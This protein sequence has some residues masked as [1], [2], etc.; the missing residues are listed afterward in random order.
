MLLF[1]QQETANFK[2]REQVSEKFRVLFG[3]GLFRYLSVARCLAVPLLRARISESLRPFWFIV[4]V[5]S[6]K[7]IYANLEN[8]SYEKSFWNNPDCGGNRLPASS[9]RA[10]FCR[11]NRRIFGR[12]SCN[13]SS[14]LFFVEEQERHRRS[15][16]KVV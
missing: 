11:N 9:Y 10:K 3:H 2:Q 1:S 6:S 5:L 7:D 14:C 16:S 4:L 15:K 12:K 8:F 13:I